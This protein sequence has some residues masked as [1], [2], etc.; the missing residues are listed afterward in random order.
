MAGAINDRDIITG[1]GYPPEQVFKFGDSE[2]GFLFIGGTNDGRRISVNT[3][4]VMLPKNYLPIIAY[5][6]IDYLQYESY[7]KK[8]AVTATRHWII[9][10]VV[11][12]HESLQ[13]DFDI[14]HFLRE[15]GVYYAS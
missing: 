13:T 12:V 8:T 11:Y 14:E 3:P 10:V 4:R 15:R 2:S 7:D 5:N 6:D 1:K 9:Y